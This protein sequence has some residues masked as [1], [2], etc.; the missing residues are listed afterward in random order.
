MVAVYKDIVASGRGD[1]FYIRTHFEYEK[2]TPQGL[3]F[4]RGDV[5]KVVDTLYDGKLGSWLVIRTDQDNQLQ[6]R[7]VIPSK[8][9]CVCVFQKLTCWC[10][11]H[12]L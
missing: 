11:Q 10:C 5:F 3:S 12:V 6:E 4:S 7:G 8:S 2:D 9:R 1:N